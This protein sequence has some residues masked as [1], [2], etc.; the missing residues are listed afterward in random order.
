M[1][2][3]YGYYQAYDGQILLDGREA[4]IRSPR[5][6]MAYGIGIVF[7]QFSLIPALS[8]MENLLLAYTCAPAPIASP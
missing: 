5:E 6:A 4:V 8:V 3:L 2:V 7:Q 1:K